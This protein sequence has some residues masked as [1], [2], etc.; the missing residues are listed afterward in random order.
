MKT[1]YIVLIVFTIILIIV[2]SVLGG[3][4]YF[5]PS[6]KTKKANC[7]CYYLDIDDKHPL[8]NPKY[9]YYYKKNKKECADSCNLSDILKDD[10]FKFQYC[11]KDEPCS[12]HPDW[13]SLPWLP[14]TSHT[15]SPTSHTST[16]ISH[17]ITYVYNR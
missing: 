9:T 2:L 7:K 11:F 4:G 6:S 3:L 12:S 14:P 10:K 1:S 5:D 8:K 15:Q 13:S 16:N 17:P